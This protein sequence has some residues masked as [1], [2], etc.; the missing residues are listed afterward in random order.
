MRFF[1][2]TYGCTMNQGESQELA[3]H[4]LEHGHEQVTDEGVADLLLVNTCVVIQ[5]TELKIMK[6]LRVLAQTGKEMV[7]AGCLPAVKGE[8]LRKEFPQAILLSPSEYEVFSE[9]IDERYGTE[10]ECGREVAGQISGVLPVSQG[11]LGN[12]TYCLTK[13]A[14]GD[15]SSYSLDAI[16]AKAK[17][18]LAEGSREL[19]V[20]AQDT[21][22]Y[23]LDINTDLGELLQ[24]LTA[25]P[26]DFM[27]RVGM[28]NPDSLGQVLEEFL[29]AWSGP[30]V[31][32]FLHL[33]VQ[34]GS[35]SV[36]RAM[37]RGY[38]A[39]TFETQVGRFRA[40]RPRMSLSTDIITGFPGETDDDHR[41][42]VEMVQRVRPN[43]I[44]VTR[45]SPRPGTPAAKAKGQVPSWI[46]KERSREMAKLR[47]DLG[48]EYY[49]SFDGETVRLLITE[50][51]K[52]GTMVGRT[53]EYAPVAVPDDGLRLGDRIDA[54]VTGHAATHLLAKRL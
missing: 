38:D 35:Q 19:L 44:N 26:G 34:S 51:G 27:V 46:S 49:A 10:R 33:P 30:K 20:T 53:M 50:V 11:C 12:C 13:K 41:A 25:L 39:R 32:K 4:L 6:R 7:I 21:G 42:S 3:R 36:L 18:L 54:K 22:C 31:Y 37:G 47:F 17:V 43:I 28:M 15:L 1:V 52:K 5:A 24:R 40:I 45:F 29:P 48:R 14:R 23:G 8:A 9:H 2:E 16:E